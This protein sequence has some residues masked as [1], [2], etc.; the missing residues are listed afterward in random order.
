MS[1]QTGSVSAVLTTGATLPVADNIL[2]IAYVRSRFNA[3]PTVAD[4][5]VSR[6]TGLA[7]IWKNSIDPTSLTLHPNS[8]ATSTMRNNTLVVC[9]KK[10]FAG[11]RRSIPLTAS[12][13]FDCTSPKVSV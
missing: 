3:A 7:G 13:H 9:P 12:V 8:G 4:T 6:Q 1:L 11:L 2:S 5:S 10:L